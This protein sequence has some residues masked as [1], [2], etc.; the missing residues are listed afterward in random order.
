MANS[1]ADG[2][3]QGEYSRGVAAVPPAGHPWVSPGGPAGETADLAPGAP[4]S[5]STRED[6]RASKRK[7]PIAPRGMIVRRRGRRLRAGAGWTWTGASFLLVCWGIWVVSVRGTDL[8]G[9]VIGL[10]LVLATGG[11]LFVLARLLGRAILEQAMGRERPSAWPSHLT[12][13]VFLTLT[14]VTFLQQ[15]W[16]VQDSGRWAGDTWQALADAWGW[17]VSW[18]P[19]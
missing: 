8:A 7:A 2:P 17:L 10:V 9:P 19:G 3:R 14:G 12:V 16:W 1:T 5:G 15:T 6:P 18:W 4:L 13:S 11:L